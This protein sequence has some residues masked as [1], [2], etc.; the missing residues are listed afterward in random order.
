MINSLLI[1]EMAIANKLG[2]PASIGMPFEPGGALARKRARLIEE[3]AA[4]LVSALMNEDLAAVAKESA[5]L[6][7]VTFGTDVAYGIPA[8]D[9]FFAV[10]GNN[11]GKIEAA[12]WDGQKLI[13]P[14]NYP[15]V[16]LTDILRAA[17]LD[18]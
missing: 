1:F 6:K 5:D 2:I 3:E 9:V 16:D 10:H 17:G 4:E 11:M 15:K 7:Y 12:S 8:H 18:V 14:R 13:K